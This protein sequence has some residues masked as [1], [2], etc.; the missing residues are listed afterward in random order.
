MPPQPPQPQCLPDGWCGASEA[1]IAGSCCSNYAVN[2]CCVTARAVKERDRGETFCVA[3]DNCDSYGKPMEPNYVSL[4]LFLHKGMLTIMTANIHRVDHSRSS[5]CPPV[6]IT[7]KVGTDTGT[8]QI[9]VS[10]QGPIPGVGNT[11]FTVHVPI[12]ATLLTPHVPGPTTNVTVHLPVPS[13]V[14]SGQ[15]ASF[16]GANTLSMR[17]QV[18]PGWHHSV[19]HH[20]LPTTLSTKVRER[21]TPPLCVI[22]GNCSQG[23]PPEDVSY[24]TLPLMSSC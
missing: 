4:A 15:H 21:A 10:T 13:S 6:M 23:P 20:P 11:H 5:K 16:Q 12:P 17:Q 1:G 14:F 22:G 18:G 19:A 8:S 3:E 24:C 9:P 2:D 7:I